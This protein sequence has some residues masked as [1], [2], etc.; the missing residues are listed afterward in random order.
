[1]GSIGRSIRRRQEKAKL[2]SA[3]KEM[4]EKIGLS[5]LL[6]EECLACEAPFDKTDEKMIN[7]WYMIVRQQP[8]TVNLYCP[9][10][11]ESVAESINA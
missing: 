11:W 6:P 4:Q 9:A 7:E 2:R 10:C 8:S 1:M 3:R 5:G